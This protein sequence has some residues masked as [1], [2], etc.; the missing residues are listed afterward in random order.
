MRRVVEFTL[1]AETARRPA[2]KT[3]GISLN[4][5]LHGRDLSPPAPN[6]T[7]TRMPEDSK[8]WMHL[9]GG[10]SSLA[11]AILVQVLNEQGGSADYEDARKRWEGRLGIPSTSGS[12]EVFAALVR[13]MAMRRVIHPPGSDRPGRLHVARPTGPV[14]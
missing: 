7:S 10:S 9:L 11:E 8:L 4:V 14:E 12:T 2:S 3:G 5:H 6:P 13:T 1:A